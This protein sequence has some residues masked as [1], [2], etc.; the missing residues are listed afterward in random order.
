VPSGATPN[1][2]GIGGQGLPFAVNGSNL[3]R[4]IGVEDPLYRSAQLLED[5]LGL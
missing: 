5:V 2:I 3:D 4:Q 1:G